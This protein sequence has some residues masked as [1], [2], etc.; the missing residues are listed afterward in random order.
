VQTY[1]DGSTKPTDRWREEE[2]KSDIVRTSYKYDLKIVS[3]TCGYL[4]QT[5]VAAV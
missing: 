5:A 4:F 3:D 2:R 1:P